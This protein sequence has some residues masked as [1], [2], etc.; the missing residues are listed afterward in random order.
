[1]S[2]KLSNLT[3]LASVERGKMDDI[4]A[5]KM[6]GFPDAGHNIA[7]DFTAISHPDMQVWKR[8]FGGRSFASKLSLGKGRS[9]KLLRERFGPLSFGLAI[10][11][12]EDRLRFIVRSWN[13][14]GILLP[15]SW[16]PGGDSYEFCEDGKFCFNVEIRHPLTGT[17]VKYRGWLE[18]KIE[19]V[20]DKQAV[21]V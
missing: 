15:L 17:I 21:C 7:V 8:T 14:L 6:L 10:V 18:P 19:S 9:D 20:K 13:F 11:I 5:A 4:L 16:A 1:M 12:D 2:G 3:R